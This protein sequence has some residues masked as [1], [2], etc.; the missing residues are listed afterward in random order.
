MPLCKRIIG[1]L[2]VKGTKLVK[3]IQFEGVR[4]LGSAKEAAQSY[5]RAG[6]DEVLYIDSVASLYGRNNLGELLRKTTEEVFIPI[7]AG[8]GIRSI[9]DAADLLASGADKIA[10]NTA[11]LERPDILK[12]LA[13][14][15]GSQ[16]I[17]LSVQAKKVSSSS[18]EAMGEA[19]RERSG[20]DVV[21]WIEMAQDYGVG[22]ILLTSVDKD[23]TCSGPDNSLMEAIKKKVRVPLIM[24]GG[25]ANVD[26]VTSTL[27]QDHI[28]GI[29]IGAAMHK[30]IVDVVDIKASCQ[31]KK[32]QVVFNQELDVSI[33]WDKE[34]CGIKV[35]IINYDMGN[36]QS[37][38][39]ALSKL[40]ATCIISGEQRDLEQCDLL[41]LPG[42]G[43]FPAGMKKIESKMLDKFIQDWI[44]KCKPLIG[45][46][47]GM[48]ILFEEGEE[49]GL[50]KGLGI[51]KGRV[52]QLPCNA[53]TKEKLPHIGWNQII[54]NS[55]IVDI[56]C[57]YSPNEQYF[58][59][60]YCATSVPEEII[61]FKCRYGS[62]DLFPAAIM[63]NNIAGFQFHPERSGRS[64]LKLLGTVCKKL[65]TNPKE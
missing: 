6:L 2:D 29:A 51:L 60:S 63:K 34:L 35:G 61:L 15:F 62:N 27:S 50:C 11:A 48:Q 19:G 22:E 24:C 30:G 55:N 18:W 54:M 20:K 31:K 10:V 28:S 43:A 64:G 36:V 52:Q 44:H 45:I 3:G 9:K 37:L 53:N 8:G 42:V 5:A 13:L 57:I 17:V 4:V 21:E 12:E 23:G 46:C 7:T 26:E 40:G 33:N 38:A 56:G 39:N 32:L 47:L 1:R 14:A 65:I 41:A 25:F 59:H 16:C 49:F 58:V